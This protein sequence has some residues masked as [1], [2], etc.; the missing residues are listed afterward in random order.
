ML[1]YLI[2]EN[3]VLLE[4]NKGKR[5]VLADDQRRRLAAKS[6]VIG[7]R[8]LMQV[9]TIVKADT[10]LGWYRK[11]IERSCSAPERRSGR[12]HVQPEIRELVVGIALEN[13]RW[14]SRRTPGELK[15]LGH[16][17]A[18][19]TIAD[20][21]SEIGIKPAPDRPTSWM[22]FIKAHLGC[23][24]GTPTETTGVSKRQDDGGGIHGKHRLGEVGDHAL[25]IA[26]SRE[27]HIWP[28][29]QLTVLRKPRC[30]RSRPCSHGLTGRGPAS[31]QDTCRKST[32]TTGELTRLS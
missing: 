2:E 22:T 14:G 13:P 8:D 9:A 6:K 4:Q 11:L 20:I 5:P 25:R 12:P 17:I 19:I 28:R 27:L 16:R 30:P 7:R 3:R 32:G 31:P 18:R 23:S 26:E 29:V 10:I 1:D 21:L 15:A 24:V